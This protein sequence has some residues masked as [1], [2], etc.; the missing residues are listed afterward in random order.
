M[1][2]AGGGGGGA[3]AAGA[4]GGRCAG[5]GSTSIQSVLRIISTMTKASKRGFSVRAIQ[6]LRSGF[7]RSRQ[8]ST[9]DA[10][11]APVGHHPRAHVSQPQ[12]P[13]RRAFFAYFSGG[14]TACALSTTSM[15]W[16]CGIFPTPGM[17]TSPPSLSSPCR[18]KG[19]SLAPSLTPPNGAPR[20]HGALS[21]RVCGST[22]S[23][24]R[25]ASIRV[26]QAPI[27][28][29]GAAPRPSLVEKL[30]RE[31]AEALRATLSLRRNGL[32]DLT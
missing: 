27:S 6:N 26:A 30:T 9:C 31:R 32:V 12:L 2:C 19:Q 14:S 7:C 24:R 21:R 17:A 29:S 20:G 28:T 11:R 4:R 22:G 18:Q 15:N 13:Q 5:G 23:A 10:H 3:G 16:S 1:W 8:K 25:R